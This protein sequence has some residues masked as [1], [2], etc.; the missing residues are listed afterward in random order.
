VTVQPLIDVSRGNVE[1]F[2]RA[3]RLRPRRDPTNDDRRYLRN[4]IRHDV[5]PELERVTG[6]SARA[7][8]VRTAD[9]LRADRREL[10]ADSYRVFGAIVNERD[11]RVRFDAARLVELSPVL[12][13]RVIRMA[14]Y[15]TLSSD[16][17]APWSREAIEAILDLARGRPGR[18][19]DLPEG[20]RA[21]RTRT[22]VEVER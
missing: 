10:E 5:L 11:D 4:A 15:R 13:G 1:A 17:A 14:V 18:T 16:W 21:R 19:R 3:L 6:R 7:S 20:R 2:C 9:L 12:A 22:H 8:I